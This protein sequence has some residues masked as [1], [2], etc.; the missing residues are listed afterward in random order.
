[1]PT[2]GT[3][4]FGSTR[5]GNPDSQWDV[6]TATSGGS[7]VAL[8]WPSAGGSPSGYELSVDGVV[9]NVGNVTSYSATGLTIGTSY[10]FKI[11][12]VYADGTVG[13]WSYFKQGGPTGFNAA[14]G[15]S[16]TTVS[17]WNGSGNT[18]KIHSFTSSSSLTVTDAPG[19]YDFSVLIV[20]GGNGANYY[21][22]TPY[23]GGQV[24]SQTMSLSSGTLSVTVGSGGS[25]GQNNATA[26]QPSTFNGVTANPGQT[27]SPVANTISGSS[28][29]YGGQGG[30]SGTYGRGGLGQAGTGQSGQPGIVI[31]AYRIA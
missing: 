12:P 23:P 22:G 29:Q 24:V 4:Y 16:E 17:N 2:T 9:T 5:L 30:T 25:G 13:G 26:G 7:A 20:A 11:R 18:Y 19:V 3:L 14:S 21:A 15:G 31:V 6:M 27:T 28:V 10:E 1:M 8:S